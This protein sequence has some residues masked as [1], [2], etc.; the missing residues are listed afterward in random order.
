VYTRLQVS[1]KHRQNR[2][3][4]NPADSPVLLETWKRGPVL[5]DGRGRMSSTGDGSV[6]RVA[7][8]GL[9]PFRWRVTPAAEKVS[10][11]L[12]ERLKIVP[13]VEK[14]TLMR[15]S[16]ARMNFMDVYVSGHVDRRFRKELRAFVRSYCPEM[17]LRI[18]RGGKIYRYLD[19]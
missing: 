5:G 16:L 6:E 18:H 12:K 11:L 17:V 3:N 19:Q 14:V 2:V 13:G 10:E 7:I 9:K 1:L 8:S 15:S 4:D